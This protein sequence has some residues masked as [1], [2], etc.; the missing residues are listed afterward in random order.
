M[1]QYALK[2]SHEDLSNVP[3]FSRV[4]DDATDSNEL[5]TSIGGTLIGAIGVTGVI[6]AIGAMTGSELFG[7]M[8]IG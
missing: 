2:K 5:G 1:F 8:I 7:S 6:G 3:A 4:W